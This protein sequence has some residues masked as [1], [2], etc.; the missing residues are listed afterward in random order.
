MN[1]RYFI[2]C[3]LAGAAL[4]AIPFTPATFDMSLMRPTGPPWS[5]LNRINIRRLLLHIEK[6]VARAIEHNIGGIPD[7]IT[8][9]DIIAKSDTMIGYMVNRTR[10]I[11]DFKV[12]CDQ[13]NNTPE[14]I[15]EGHLQVDVMIQPLK[16]I[17]M[18]NLNCLQRVL[19]FL[20]TGHHHRTEY[21][22]DRF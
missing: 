12:K 15:D 17:E 8:R 7:Q 10:I 6:S 19:N 20:I 5:A 9:N 18:I 4:T 11:K 16:V 22:H 21:E 3:I 14:M 2:K 13:E 1:R